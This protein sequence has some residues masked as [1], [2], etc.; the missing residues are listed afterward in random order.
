MGNPAQGRFPMD[1]RPS[2]NLA[3]PPKPSNFPF[4]GLLSKFMPKNQLDGRFGRGKWR[5]LRRR[6]IEHHDKV[7]GID[8]I[9][10]AHPGTML[11]HISSRP[12]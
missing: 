7:R 9:T 6:G 8:Y 10:P 11:R 4:P 3:S 2:A 5:A 12:S 1:S